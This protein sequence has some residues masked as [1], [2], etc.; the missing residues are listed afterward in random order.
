[1]AAAFFTLSSRGAFFTLSSRG[2]FFTLP[3]RGAFFTLPSRGAFF[4]D[5]KAFT[6][7]IN[8]YFNFVHAKDINLM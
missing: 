2:A 7:F 5:G 4:T 1:M 6:V 3:S 8:K